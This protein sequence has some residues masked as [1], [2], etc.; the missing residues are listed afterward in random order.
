MNILEMQARVITEIGRMSSCLT[1]D[2]ELLPDD[3]EALMNEI[4]SMAKEVGLCYYRLWGYVGALQQGINRG[5]R[6]T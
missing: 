2:Q 3:P 1:Y 4:S 6:P 5:K